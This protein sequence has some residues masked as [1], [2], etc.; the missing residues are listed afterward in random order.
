MYDIN[1]AGISAKEM[2]LVVPDRPAIPRAVRR[3]ES[4]AVKGRDGNMYVYDGSVEDIRISI[5][6][7]FYTPKNEWMGRLR[8]VAGWLL[9]RPTMEPWL[10]HLGDYILDSSNEKILLSSSG[11]K[12]LYLSDDPD[13]CYRV[14]NVQMGSTDREARVFGRF[15][16]DFICE[17]YSYAA[18][19]LV[20]KTISQVL[21]NP[22]EICKPVYHI[23]GNG[24]CTITINERE[25]AIIV[26][27]E[28]TIDSEYMIA[29]RDDGT[30]VNADVSGDYERLWLFPGDNTITV[31]SGFTCGVTPRW[32]CL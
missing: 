14:K 9:R 7:A 1:Y 28:A 25:F 3:Y 26:G 22:Y 10:D 17:G 32:R 27:G 20:E 19:G 6:L 29:Y 4:I 16:V 13:F 24:N 11:S 31:P 8:N 12:Y 23:T 18:D 15:T 2:G 21:Q 5:G 30:L